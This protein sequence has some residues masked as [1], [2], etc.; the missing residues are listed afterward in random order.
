MSPVQAKEIGTG[1]KVVVVVVDVVVVDVLVV[2]VVDSSTTE[3]E[4][5]PVVTFGSAASVEAVP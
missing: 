1:G 4:A 3:A 2:E 5:V